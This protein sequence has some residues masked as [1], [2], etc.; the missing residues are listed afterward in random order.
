MVSLRAVF[1]ALSSISV[2]FAY[3]VDQRILILSPTADGAD[4]PQYSLKSYSIPFDTIIVTPANPI[5]GDITLRNADGSGKY[6]AIVIANDMISLFPNGSYIPTLLNHQYGQIFDYQLQYNVRLVTLG[7]NPNVFVGS[8]TS[9][10]DGTAVTSLGWGVDNAQDI[11]VGSNTG[12]TTAAGL[13]TALSLNSKGLFHFPSTLNAAI[14][15]PAAATEVLKFA[16]LA[17]DY[18]NPTTAA[19]VLKYANGREKMAFYFT[20]GSWSTTS[21][22]LSHIWVQWATRTTYNGFRRI[23]ATAQ[24]DDFF[25]STEGNDETGKFVNFRT[26]PADMQA[27]EAWQADFTSKRLPPGSKYVVELAYN[28][29]GVMEKANTLQPSYYVDFDPDLTDTPLDWKKPLGTGMTLWKANQASPWETNDS[30]LKQADPLYAYFA[31][32]TLPTSKFY[33]CSHTFTHEILNNCTY[34]DAYKEIQFN[35]K[36]AK[37]LGLTL[38]GNLASYSPGSMVTPGIS[39]IFN[40]DALKALTDL[41]VKASVGDS[42][43]PKVQNPANPFWWPMFTTVADNGF[44]NFVVIPRQSLNIFF[45]CTNPEYNTILYNKIYNETLGQL[46][47]RTWPEILK[48]ETDRNVRILAS[49]SWQPYMF[50]QANLRNADAAPSI[51]PGT[52]ATAKLGLLQI[53]SEN[54]FYGYRKVA[55]W[56]IVSLK[57]DDLTKKFLDRYAYETG[58]VKLSYTGTTVNGKVNITQMVI[59]ASKSACTAPISIPVGS[60]TGVTMKTTVAVTMERLTNSNDPLTIWVP[61]KLNTPVTLT[62]SPGLVV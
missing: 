22:V 11:I 9:K 26:S 19:A 44:A 57:Q 59:V 14:T 46:P 21:I 61:L 33:W 40:G 1:V 31:G 58:G 60:V 35:Q 53:W 27:L 47:V 56:P 7:E 3:V 24:V 55:N 34:S 36:L 15:A 38:A 32:K 8:P 4:Q 30:V 50:H 2:A 41:G 13:N 43:R 48:D 16:A 5:V 49:L 37:S 20:L 39:G 45:N 23:Y 51:I 62:F 18:P 17:P 42:S 54:V 6:S 29:N 28:G 52:T 25:L 12:F 10:D